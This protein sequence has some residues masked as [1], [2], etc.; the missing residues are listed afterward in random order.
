MSLAYHEAELR[1]ALD[2]TNPAHNLPPILP[3][4]KR[5][6]DVGCGMGQTLLAARLAPDVEA[7][8]VDN[9][10]AAVRAGMNSMP[11]N[12]NLMEGSGESLPFPDDY[13]DLVYSRVALP[14]MQ[15][16]KALKEINRV[17]KPGGDVWLSLMGVN[18]LSRKTRLHLKQIAYD[19][20]VLI[21]GTLFNLFGT[22]LPG[23]RKETFQT[24][25]GIERAMRRVG[26]TARTTQ[27][28]IHLT[29]EGKK[30]AG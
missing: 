23:K 12:I 5:I 26:L 13:F 25:G 10:G 30:F 11:P 15:V 6:L 8:G 2:P 28:A 4:H 1:I 24:K 20:F 14:C 29:A 27:S 22:Q 21:N 7:F 16:S 17:L 3:H 9:D 18:H 19:V